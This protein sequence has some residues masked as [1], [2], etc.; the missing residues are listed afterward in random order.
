MS[1]RHSGSEIHFTSYDSVKAGDGLMPIRVFKFSLDPS[2]LT[3]AATT[4]AVDISTDD[5]GNAFPANAL[6]IGA[7]VDVNTAFT[8]GTVSACTVQVGDTADPNELLVAT[9]CFTATGF[10]WDPGVY[11]PFSLEAAYAPEALVT[12][13]GDNV[14]AI[15]AG[16]MVIRIYY[17][18]PEAPAV[19]AP[20]TS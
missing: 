10:T 15:T 16:L 13:T 17:F 6:V 5:E 7:S 9:S 14:D 18:L 4:E 11:T 12:A 19:T 2:D 3:A 1:N 8:G 20:P